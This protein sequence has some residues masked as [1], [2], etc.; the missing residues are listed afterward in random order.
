M[1][2]DLA[3]NVGDRIKNYREA[4]NLTQAELAELVGCSANHISAIERGLYCTR[5]DTLIALSN[6]LEVSTD[7]LLFG[8]YKPTNIHLTKLFNQIC[9]TYGETSVYCFLS[10][11]ISFNEKRKT[12]EV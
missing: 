6:A 5:I 4:K 9:D 8:E 3:I 10:S 2:T 1:Y 7:I 11:L 12:N